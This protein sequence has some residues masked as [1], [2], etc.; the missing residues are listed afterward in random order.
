MS[1]FRTPLPVDV[2]AVKALLPEQSHVEDITLDTT[3]DP[4]AVVLQWSNHRLK[5]PYSVPHDFPIANLKAGPSQL[6][7]NVTIVEWPPKPKTP[8][9]A[10]AKPEAKPQ[11]QPKICNRCGKVAPPTHFDNNLKFCSEKCHREHQDA[12]LAKAG[13]PTPAAPAKR[14]QAIKPLAKE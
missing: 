9:E 12:K 2:A 3:Q 14:K 6:P 10:A 7:E 8:P 1:T 13:V 5:T 11:A 4:P